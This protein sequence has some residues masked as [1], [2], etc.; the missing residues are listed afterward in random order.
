MT[1][2]VSLV[3]GS[4]TMI[5]LPLVIGFFLAWRNDI[6]ETKEHLRRNQ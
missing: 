5:I 3:C 2:M 6:V 1:Q 4:I